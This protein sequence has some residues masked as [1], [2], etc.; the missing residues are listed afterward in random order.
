MAIRLNQ[1]I[2]KSFER[3]AGPDTFESTSPEIGSKK[4]EM[5]GTVRRS[6]IFLQS[7]EPRFANGSVEY[8]AVV[9][10]PDS[11]R[12]TL[13]YKV[14]EQFHS[15]V[16]ESA[17]PFLVAVIFLASEHNADI[18]VRGS[19]SPSLISNLSKFLSQWQEWQPWRLNVVEITAD[20]L[21]ESFGNR[22]GKRAVCAFSAGLD[23]SYTIYRHCVATSKQADLEQPVNIEAALLAHGFDIPL[24]QREPFDRLVASS[25]RLL[26]DIGLELITL[27]T[28][29]RDIV[30]DWS[31]GFGTA[32]VS[33]LMLFK[34]HFDTGVIAADQNNLLPNPWGSNP[35]T[36]PFLSSASFS[37]WHDAFDHVRATKLKALTDWP[38]AYGA[39]RVC[40]SHPTDGD[41][42]CGRCIKC[43]T[44]WL[45]AVCSGCKPPAS[46]P[47][48]TPETVLSM[49]KVSALY[50]E[51]LEKMRESDGWRNVPPEISKSITR[52]MKFHSRQL[53][54][55]ECLAP[56]KWNR[57]PL[58]KNVVRKAM[59]RLH[60]E[61]G[62]YFV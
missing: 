37:L 61:L 60:S 49:R 26:G 42:N 54:V 50:L 48:P 9:E 29:Y 43:T 58:A 45:Y 20:T 10:L 4:K 14:P 53:L 27:E 8:A 57:E 28:N 36:D 46:L 47:A 11:S 33:S 25:R 16:T 21:S 5:S 30:K 40:W 3:I 17:D 35:I 31:I 44:T 55:E 24:N 34:N 62:M 13:W 39:L 15:W 2:N 22:E 51:R 18:V 38:E 23:S 12:K 19:V 32:L 56:D 41:K 7:E 1:L 6:K 59:T 52:A